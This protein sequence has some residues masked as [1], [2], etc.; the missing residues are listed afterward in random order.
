VPVRVDLEATLADFA[1]RQRRAVHRPVELGRERLDA[2]IRRIPRPETLLQPQAQRLD[3]LSERLRRGLI[4]RAGQG[5]EKL[6]G[7]QARLTPGTLKRKHVEAQTRLSQTHLKPGLIERPLKTGRDQLAA[8]TR[9]ASQ[10]HPEKPLARGYAIVRDAQGKALTG[11][12]QAAKESALALQ[13]KDGMLEVGV[14]SAPT[15]QPARTPKPKRKPARSDASSAQD[16]LF[17]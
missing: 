17:G 13:F 5:R 1:T 12:V 3:E 11:K 15:P 7:I 16:D 14:G 8:L 2:R 10:L 6:A 9:I 4:D